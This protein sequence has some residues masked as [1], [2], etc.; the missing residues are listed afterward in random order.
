[1]ATVDDPV[2]EEVKPNEPQTTVP[3]TTT[4]A[5]AVTVAPLA[6]SSNPCVNGNC[7][8]LN[9]GGYYCQCNTG[10]VGTTCNTGMAPLIT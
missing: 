2:K 6:C 10:F 7:L 3:M 9:G 1:M 5:A 8:D 4:S